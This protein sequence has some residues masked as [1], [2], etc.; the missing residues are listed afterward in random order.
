MCAMIFIF[1]IIVGKSEITAT[2]KQ[3]VRS[4]LQDEFNNIEIITDSETG[5][6][7]YKIPVSK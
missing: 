6:K 2:V 7:F 3:E 5:E 1:G 4:E